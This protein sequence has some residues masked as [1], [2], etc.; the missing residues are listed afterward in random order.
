MS[1]AKLKAAPAMVETVT[2][3]RAR[4]QV[5]EPWLLRS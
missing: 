5:K 4:D 2:V 1:K 3:R